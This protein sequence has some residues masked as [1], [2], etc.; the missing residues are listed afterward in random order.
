M[1]SKKAHVPSRNPMRILLSTCH[2]N[3]E[4]N[5]HDASNLSDHVPHEQAWSPKRRTFLHETLC[6]LYYVLVIKNHEQDPNALNHVPHEQAWSP[7]RRMFPSRTPCPSG[8][9]LAQVG[10]MAA[11]K[12]CYDQY[13]CHNKN[14]AKRVYE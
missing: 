1:E 14:N 4:H 9:L 3:H 2:K 13:I 10:K 8:Q 5:S 11:K 12:I 7:K 6:V